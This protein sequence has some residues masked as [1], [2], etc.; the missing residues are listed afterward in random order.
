MGHVS[1]AFHGLALHSVSEIIMDRSTVLLLPVA[2]RNMEESRVD[3]TKLQS[4]SHI[5]TIFVPAFRVQNRLLPRDRAFRQR[6]PILATHYSGTDARHPNAR[7]ACTRILPF[8]PPAVRNKLLLLSVR[9]R[10][11][12]GGTSCR[13][14]WQVLAPL[15]QRHTGPG[16][17][18]THFGRIN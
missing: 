2:W 14:Q 18:P 1:R 13:H 17:T 11:N 12:R 9:G 3:R 6:N 10:H 4:L 16:W 5:L 8:G 15:P 7:T